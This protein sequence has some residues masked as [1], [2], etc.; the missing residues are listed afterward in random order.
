MLIEIIQRNDAIRR[1]G[2]QQHPLGVKLD[3]A[4]VKRVIAQKPGLSLPVLG[5]LQFQR[6][7]LEMRE[8]PAHQLLL[9]SFAGVQLQHAARAAELSS[10]QKA[11]DMAVIMTLPSRTMDWSRLGRETIAVVVCFVDESSRTVAPSA[12]DLLHGLI[13]TVD[14]DCSSHCSLSK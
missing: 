13:L 14:W 7:W 10:V 1:T 9:L 11:C 2:D 5:E 12:A 3:A 6:E 4:R 8:Y